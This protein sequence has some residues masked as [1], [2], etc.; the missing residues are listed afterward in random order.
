VKTATVSFKDAE[1]RVL[2]DPQAIDEERL[3]VAIE[4]PGYR[5]VKPL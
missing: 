5:V 2:F 3:T 1:A 4:K